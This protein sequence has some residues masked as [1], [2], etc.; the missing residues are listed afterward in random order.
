MKFKSVKQLKEI[1]NNYGIR[2]RYVMN[3]KPN[4]KKTVKT[5]WNRICPFYL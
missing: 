3:F 2:N 1:V 5:F 4:S